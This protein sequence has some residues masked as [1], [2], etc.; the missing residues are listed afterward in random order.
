VK[1]LEEK[2]SFWDVVGKESGAGYILDNNVIVLAGK[3]RKETSET[4]K[5]FRDMVQAIL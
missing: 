5:L 4:G 1:L 3:T 2:V